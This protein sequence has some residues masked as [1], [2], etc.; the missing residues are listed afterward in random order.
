MR[1]IVVA[2][3]GSVAAVMAMASF[4]SVF[5]MPASIFLFAVIWLAH[6]GQQLPAS[7]RVVHHGFV[8]RLLLALDGQQRVVSDFGCC[9]S[10][11]I[12][13]LQGHKTFLSGILFQLLML[14]AFDQV[15]DSSLSKQVCFHF[16]GRAGL[17]V[18]RPLVHPVDSVDSLL[19]AR[20]LQLPLQL[21]LGA[22]FFDFIDALLRTLA[23]G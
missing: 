1:A 15:I 8:C 12:C 22:L 4:M 18:G 20:S 6:R 3:S 14:V 9:I 10:S 13:I 7:D 11:A 23:L 2:L 21:F 16:L 19:S 5:A 17:A